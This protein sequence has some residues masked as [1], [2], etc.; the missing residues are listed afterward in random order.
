MDREGAEEGHLVGAEL[1]GLARD[2]G[3]GTVE[4]VAVYERDDGRRDQTLGLG[5]GAVPEARVGR[6]VGDDHRLARGGRRPDQA[7]ARS[8]PVEVSGVV[9]AEP[10]AGDLVE[11]LVTLRLLPEPPGG[12][13]DEDPGR[14]EDVARD[15]R[16]V[17]GRRERA[18]QLG[19][20]GQALGVVTGGREEPGVLEGDG[21]GGREQRDQLPVRFGERPAAGVADGEGPDHPVSVEERL[22]DDRRRVRPVHEDGR[23]PHEGRPVGHDE[24]PPP[25][26]RDPR[27]PFAAAEAD[28]AH[29]VAQSAPGPGHQGFAGVVPQ[30]H[31]ARRAPGELRGPPEHELDQAA[32]VPL[33][34]D[35]LAGRLERGHL[36]RAV[37]ERRVARRQLGRA[38]KH[39]ALHPS[40][41]GGEGSDV[42]RDE[43]G[44]RQPR[45]QGGPRAPG[46]KATRPK[47]GEG[48]HPRPARHLEGPKLCDVAR[49][50][51]RLLLAGDAATG[52][53][54]A[55]VHEAAR[56]RRRSVVQLD[57]EPSGGE[58]PDGRLDEAVHG[59][60]RR[61]EA[62]ERLTAAA[63]V[64]TTAP[65][66]Y[67]GAV[68]RKP[69]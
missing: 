43:T 64:S 40:G 48:D 3:E 31:H 2:D 47:W 33:A 19:Q 53:G 51:G 11:G 44:Q 20:G 8:E 66:R 41:P 57:G 5:P 7:L 1:V 37:G 22:R 49:T 32:E 52:R 25:R 30:V 16:R 26:D 54:V 35:L 12:A 29:L 68:T 6:E 27:G 14:L 69:T 60:G 4:P 58:P 59:E 50:R 55:S 67:R 38:Q 34:R 13:R 23:G 17:E 36:P 62:D 15:G 65:D 46:A 61:D 42:G 24:P 45:Y 39:L 18:R 63:S 10:H 21:R 9:V 28:V 56:G